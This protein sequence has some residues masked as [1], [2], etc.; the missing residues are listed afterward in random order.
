MDKDEDPDDYYLRHN[1]S[2]QF[3][4]RRRV[5]LSTVYNKDNKPMI[6]YAKDLEQL[7][8]QQTEEFK[9]DIREQ[10]RKTQEL[11]IFEVEQEA[12]MP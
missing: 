7:K 4:I 9:K 11:R 5:D 10:Q 12:M 3:E 8:K 1:G 2:G 6:F